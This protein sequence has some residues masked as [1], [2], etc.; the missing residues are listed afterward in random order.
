MQ[1][2]QTQQQKSRESDRTAYLIVAV[3]VGFFAILIGGALWQ[4]YQDSALQS[5]YDRLSFKLDVAACHGDYL[6]EQ[7]VLHHHQLEQEMK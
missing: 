5:D 2:Q 7:R 6:C 1:A 3:V 4:N